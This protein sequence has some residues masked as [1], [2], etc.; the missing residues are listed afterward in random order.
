MVVFTFTKI[1]LATHE[2]FIGREQ[3]EKQGGHLEDCCI[4][5]EVML[6]GP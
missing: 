6:F 1:I 3:E 4:H 2:E 5:P